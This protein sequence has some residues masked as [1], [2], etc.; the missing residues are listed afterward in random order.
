MVAAR[1]NRRIDIALLRPRRA[2]QYCSAG[3][4]DNDSEEDGEIIE[5]A[6]CP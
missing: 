1:M 6:G 4:G 2:R 5:L 3:G